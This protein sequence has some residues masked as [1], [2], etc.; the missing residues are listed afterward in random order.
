MSETLHWESRRVS[1]TNLNSVSVQS[2][3]YDK[4]LWMEWLI[5]NTNLALTVLES[6]KLRSRHRRIGYLV[7]AHFL[8]HRWLSFCYNLTGQKE[9]GSS[10]GSLMR[11]WI[12][13]VGAV[14]SRPNRLPKASP[15]STITL[16]VRKSIWIWGET[17]IQPMLNKNYTTPMWL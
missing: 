1:Y 5:N 15:P 7:K 11:A 2:Y 17:K 12:P 3:C 14:P 4:M 10:P 16:G 6:V 8:V 13:F 9:W